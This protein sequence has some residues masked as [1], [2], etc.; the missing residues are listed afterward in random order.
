G[1]KGL[2]QRGDDGPVDLGQRHGGAVGAVGRALHGVAPANVGVPGG[3]A[4]LRRDQ[5]LAA[6]RATVSAGRALGHPRTADQH[7]A[8]QDGPLRALGPADELT[9]PR[10]EKRGL[11][12]LELLVRG[13]PQLVAD[14]AERRVLAALPLGLGHADA[15][16]LALAALLAD[17]AEHLDASVH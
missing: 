12:G 15:D 6:E 10:A 2:A 4:A 5:V 1:A 16:L 3:A 7:V 11:V 14:D 17:L 13:L 9:A 8:Q